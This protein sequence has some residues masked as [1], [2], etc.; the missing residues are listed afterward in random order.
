MSDEESVTTIEVLLRRV[1]NPEG[2]M[3]FE[4]KLPDNYSCIEVLGMLA[5][6]QAHVFK[7]MMG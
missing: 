2:R 4:M 7:A 3:I 6:A 5:A 1:I